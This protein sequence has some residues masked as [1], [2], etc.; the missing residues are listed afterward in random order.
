MR[1]P[2]VLVVEDDDTIRRLLIEYL[3]DHDHLS[4]E[5]ARDGVEALHQ[6]STAEYSVVILDVMM[7]KM[8]G[9]DLLDSLTA[10][11]SDPS[12][13][14]IGH[15]PAIVVITSAPADALPDELIAQRSRNLVRAVFRKPIR[16][17]Q[18]A[19][20]VERFIRP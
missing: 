14:S 15:L 10:M 16:I 13:K 6:I 19:E 18:L 3:T 8:S 11:T 4:V 17:E 5:G 20:T 2:N 12:V 9:F 1:A 7:P